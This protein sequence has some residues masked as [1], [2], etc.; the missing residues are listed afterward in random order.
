M[1][2]NTENCIFKEYSSKTGAFHFHHAR[3]SAG[4]ETLI[5]PESHRL[6]EVLYLISGHLEYSIEGEHYAVGEGD[7]ILISPNEIHSLKIGGETAYER[8]VVMFDIQTLG[9]I[10]SEERVPLHDLLFNN[11]QRF[12]VIKREMAERNKLK[13]L[14]FSIVNDD[15]PK[16]YEQLAFIASVIRLIIAMDKLL[17]SE[18]ASFWNSTTVNPII[19]NIIEY[20]NDNIHEPLRLDDIAKHVYVSKST[21]CHKFRQDMNISL[22]RYIT[23]KKIYRAQELI[24]GG[25]S[26]Q[27]ASTAIG[28]EN[29]NSF[30]YNYKKIIGVSPSEAK[31]LK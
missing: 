1:F 25:M 11:F 8:I 23:I 16:E 29:Y 27:Q 6:F 13:D 21:I 4:K 5:G 30:F 14:F 7:V 24:Q 15:E 18:N 28:Y 10:L 26:A 19:K 20:I 9:S 17:A 3:L 31:P 2:M 22:N 12:R